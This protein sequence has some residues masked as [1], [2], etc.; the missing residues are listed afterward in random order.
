MDS[1]GLDLHAVLLLVL[2]VF[3]K[4]HI[5]IGELDRVDGA[6]LFGKVL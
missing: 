1:L 4:S 6:H 3:D 5:S 2:V